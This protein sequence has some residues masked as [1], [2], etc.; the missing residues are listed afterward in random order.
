[1]QTTPPARSQF[2][3]SG[4]AIAGGL[5]FLPLDKTSFIPLAAQM[6]A[7][8]EGMIR[9]G[10]L[11]VGDSMPGHEELIRIYGVSKPAARQAMELMRNRGYLI[12]RK[13]RGSFVSRPKVE[14]DLARIRS[15]TEEME[16]L[17]LEPGARVVQAGKRVAGG[18][19]AMQLGIFRGTPVFQ[20]KRVRTAD[21]TPIAIEESNL[22]LTRF[23]GIE[24]EDFSNRSL[25]QLL[26]DHYGQRFTHVDEMLEAHPATRAEARLLD[27]TPRSCLL[28]IRRTVWGADGRPVEASNTLYRGDRY[29]ATFRSNS[30]KSE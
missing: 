11:K 27:I 15:F 3:A 10:R 2:G 7:Q 9:S 26:R 8:L 28:R 16:A 5:P 23:A 24:A 12:R 20:L 13:G 22:E 14:K 21:G 4:P 1:M 30:L 17:G 19:V 18:E 6:Q 29:R 25:Y